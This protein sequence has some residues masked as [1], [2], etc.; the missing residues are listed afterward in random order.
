MP[1]SEEEKKERNRAR[2]RAW[3]EQRKDD[4]E[5]IEKRRARGR[6]YRER[7]RD[8]CRDYYHQK[9]NDPEFME[10]KRAAKRQYDER[11]RE[12]RNEYNRRYKEENPEK[13]RETRR[14]YKASPV[15]IKSSRIDHWKQRGVI[16]D[17]WDEL[18]NTYLSHKNCED[19]GCELTE[20]KT[21]TSKIGR[22][23]V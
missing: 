2:A 8:K 6:D 7:N 13:V 9:K 5:F 4:P 14:N 21:R 3:L 11:N 19:C 15:G 16:C 18:Y 20:D 17:D 23:H 10:R 1:L 22:A 12:Q